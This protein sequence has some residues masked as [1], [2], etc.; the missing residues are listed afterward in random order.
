MHIW[1]R[2]SSVVSGAV[3]L[4]AG[5]AALIAYLPIAAGLALVSSAAIGWSVWIERYPPL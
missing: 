3:L 2:K 5:M 1:L 4:S